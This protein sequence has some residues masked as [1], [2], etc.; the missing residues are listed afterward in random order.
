M[1]LSLY[2]PNPHPRR[3]GDQPR[4]GGPSLLGLDDERLH[5][6]PFRS[7]IAFAVVIDPNGFAGAKRREYVKDQSIPVHRFNESGRNREI[8]G[9]RPE[10]TSNAEPP[11]RSSR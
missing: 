9:Q 5:G 10:P 11:G 2:R 4:S 1:A 8:A 7:E 3:N 6:T